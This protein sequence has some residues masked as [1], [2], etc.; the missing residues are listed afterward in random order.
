M[1][2]HGS[3]HQ[4]PMTEPWF[5]F[6]QDQ[7]FFNI[8]HNNM[9]HKLCHITHWL[10]IKYDSLCIQGNR[11]VRHW[12]DAA[13]KYLQFLNPVYSLFAYLN[14]PDTGYMTAAFSETLRYKPRAQLFCFH[15][16]NMLLDFSAGEDCPCPE[17]IQEELHAFHEDLRLHCGTT[18]VL[19][20]Q[21]L[22]YS[23]PHTHTHT[24]YSIL[25]VLYGLFSYVSYRR[26]YK[27]N[28]TLS[29]KKNLVLVCS[30]RYSHGRRRGGT[31]Y[32]YKRS[33]AL[34]VI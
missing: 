9:A 33:S 25:Y 21:S 24:M 20:S 32:I 6:P 5:A 10:E 2:S 30:C 31:W 12:A 26:T 22:F 15:Q 7:S 11:Q 27:I 28:K 18:P 13:I 3:I 4:A 8:S 16:I 34:P 14:P 29:K 19:V 1:I 23:L 17:D